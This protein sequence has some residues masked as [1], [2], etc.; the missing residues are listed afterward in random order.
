MMKETRKAARRMLGIE[1]DDEAKL[2]AHVVQQIETYETLMARVKPGSSGIMWDV[3]A[4]ILCGKR[5]PI[6]R[7]LKPKPEKVTQEAN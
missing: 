2:E 5:N 7:K 1:G 4:V 6:E 3:L